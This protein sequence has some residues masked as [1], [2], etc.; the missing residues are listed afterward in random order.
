MARLLST[1]AGGRRPRPAR[2]GAARAA[3]RHRCADQR[4]G[5]AST[6]P[7]WPAARGSSASTARAPRSAS[8]PSDGCAP[9][10]S[11][12]GWASSGARALGAG[13]LATSGRLRGGVLEPARRPA[14]SR[15]GAF[16]VVAGRARAG[17]HH[18]RP[19]SPHALR[20]SCATHMLAHGADIRVVQELLGHVSIGTTQLY[21]KVSAEHLRSRLRGG[22]PP[23][24]PEGRPQRLRA[25]TGL[26]PMGGRS[27][28]LRGEPLGL[29]HGERRPNVPT[30]LG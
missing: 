3:L 29:L 27:L 9:R 8:C 25:R 18:A 5:R 30:R 11:T 26:S 28:P 6:S 10:H 17:R 12:R 13:A 14:V 22:P 23:G 2:P 7:T 15:Q 21:T 4:G 19:V 1:V 20:H 24:R 16:E